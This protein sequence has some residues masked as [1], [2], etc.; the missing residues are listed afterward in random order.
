[1]VVPQD[2]NYPGRRRPEE[3]EEV[4]VFFVGAHRWKEGHGGKTI[5][6][7]WAWSAL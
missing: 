6:P 7:S 1:M 5:V 4:I 2:R 3:A